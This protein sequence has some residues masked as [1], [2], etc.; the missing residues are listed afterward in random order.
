MIIRTLPIITEIEPRVYHA[1]FKN[2]RDLAQ[3]MM[4][5]QEYYES[6]SDEICGQYFTLE[7]FYH[8]FTNEDG[9]FEYTNIW[10]GFNVPGH[11]IMQWHSLFAPRDGLTNKE[12]QLFARLFQLIKDSDNIRWYLIATSKSDHEHKNAIK[13]EIAHARY[14]L[15]DNYRN[16]CLEL[17][18]EIHDTDYVAIR[19]LLISMGYS[20]H[21]ID[22]EI[23]AYMSTGKKADIRRWFSNNRTDINDLINRFRKNF[24]SK[25]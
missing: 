24:K 23:Q 10:T 25:K 9:E 6:I 4:R 11:I 7:E 3:S 8:H 20:D 14:Y 15:N 2:Q 12:N 18:K 17:I 22:D 21:V 16:K 19:D 13:H 5:L 1:E